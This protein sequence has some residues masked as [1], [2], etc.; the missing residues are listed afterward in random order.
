MRL[1]CW[2]ILLFVGFICWPHAWAKKIKLT[3]TFTPSG[4]F[5]A[6]S[7]KLKGNLVKKDGILQ[8]ER[9]WVNAHT[10]RT[11]VKLRDVHLTRYL[12]N[13]RI[14]M[15]DIKAQNGKGEGTLEINGVRQ[16]ILMNY[17]DKNN[18]VE[19]TFD[20]DAAEFNLPKVDFLGI[21]VSN[22]VK[23]WV[24]APYRI[25]KEKETKKN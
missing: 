14:S 21:G 10:F 5:E 17:T 11:E 3:M 23:V 18:H 6:I 20:I 19:V 12:N 22:L 16:P 1:Y 24:S 7:E 25:Y 9:L 4:S 8:S 13:S 15:F 2:S